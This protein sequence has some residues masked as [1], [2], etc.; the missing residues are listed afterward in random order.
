MGIN[1]NPNLEEVSGLVASVRHP[2]KLWAHN[3]SGNPAVLFLLDSTGSTVTSFRIAGARNRD[4]EDIAIGGPD[5]AAVLFIGDIGDNQEHRQVKYI[6]CVKEPMDLEQEELPV[7]DTLKIQFE[8]RPRDSEA[9][10]A[11]PVSGNLFLITKREREVRLYEIPYPFVSDTLI[12][13]SVAQLPLQ[14]I[15]AGDISRDGSEILL[16]NYTSI[17]YWRRAPGQSVPDALRQPPVELPYEPEPQGE[18]IAWAGDGSGYFTL[19]ENGKG[20]RGKLL[21]YSRVSG[22]KKSEVNR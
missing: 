12:L 3:D 9:L 2:G 6:Y 7:V 18:T 10:L 20:E 17:Y 5:S 8:G 14:H 19:S 1:Q 15:T 22:D 21:F 4:W 11:D 16:R 13:E